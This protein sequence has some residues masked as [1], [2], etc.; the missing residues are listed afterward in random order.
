MRGHSGGGLGV[1]TEQQALTDAVRAFAEQARARSEAR[2]LAEAADDRLPPSWPALAAQELL[3]LPFDGSVLDVCVAVE[4]FGYALAPGPVL[5]TMLAAL[6]VRRHGSEALRTRTDAGLRDGG[7]S[8]AVLVEDALIG[9]A[10]VSAV[11]LPH[12]GRWAVVDATTLPL[13]SHVGIDPTRRV[14]TAA[15]PT[16]APDAD[17]VLRSLTA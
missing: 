12:D 8:A 14:A 9:G 16:V 3:A 10:A 17:D 1:S 15:A 11:L 13:T 6:L 2:A 7:F 4:A 5:P